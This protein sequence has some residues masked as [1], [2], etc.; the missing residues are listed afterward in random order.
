MQR[1]ARSP[2]YAWSARPVPPTDQ[3]RGSTIGLVLSVV[4]STATSVLE[5]LMQASGVDL[6][7]WARAEA[8]KLRQRAQDT[9]VIQR[10]GSAVQARPKAAAA[11]EFLRVHAPDTSFYTTASYK[12]AEYG[13]AQPQS[14]LNR[15]AE[16]LEDWAKY[17]ED[18]LADALPSLARARLTASTDL[19][20]QVQQLLD[21]R[22]MHP[23]APVVLAGAALEEF[24]RARVV[25][26]AANVTGKPGITA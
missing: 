26:R 10:M 18:G 15:V 23:A 17:V 24:L 21:D 7:E 9:D 11:L 12:L 5:K 22:A 13:Q 6:I 25:T 19:M 4:G 14:A 20:E 1:P 8:V 16:L 3:C 2:Q